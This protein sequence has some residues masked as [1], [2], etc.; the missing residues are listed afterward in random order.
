VVATSARMLAPAARRARAVG[1][2]LPRS[3]ASCAPPPAAPARP[4]PSP[5]SAPRSPRTPSTPGSCAVAPLPRAASERSPARAVASLCCEA[6]GRC[7]RVRPPGSSPPRPRAG[8]PRAS[9]AATAAPDARDRA[10]RSSAG[11]RRCAAAATG[12]AAAPDVPLDRTTRVLATTQRP[13]TS[14]RRPRRRHAL[15]QLAVAKRQSQKQRW[16]Q[17]RRRH[18]QPTQACAAAV[19]AAAATLSLPHQQHYRRL[20]ERVVA[21]AVTTMQRQRV[22]R[23]RQQPQT[24]QTGRRLATPRQGTSRDCWRGCGCPPAAHRRDCGTATLAASAHA[25][26][27][28]IILQAGQRQQR[29]RL[30]RWRRLPRR[31]P[32]SPATATRPAARTATAVRTLATYAWTVQGYPQRRV[33]VRVGCLQL[34]NRAAAIPTAQRSA[35]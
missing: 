22:Q 28:V 9:A 25:A 7:G 6:C 11:H 10:Q 21:V 23:R 17:Q 29:L 1:Q 33:P 4:A 19:E 27:W 30:R 12:A 16:R 3:A 32:A 14:I 31:L 26:S 20:A 34:R 15:T 18:G 13:G 24:T 5:G 2:S 8:S 35:W